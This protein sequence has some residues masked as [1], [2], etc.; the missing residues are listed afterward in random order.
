MAAVVSEATLAA[1][2]TLASDAQRRFAAR[3]LFVVARG[4]GVRRDATERF[5]HEI[6]DRWETA[7]EEWLEALA[8]LP[9][10]RFE[11]ARAESQARPAGGPFASGSDRA[12]DVPDEVAEPPAS[13]RVDGRP[14]GEPLAREGSRGGQRDGAASSLASTAVRGAVV[15]PAGAPSPRREHRV[16]TEE[17]EAAAGGLARA[18]ASGGRDE[19]DAWRRARPDRLLAPRGRAAHADTAGGRHPPA[20]FALHGG[21]GASSSG[22]DERSLDDLRAIIEEGERRARARAEWEATEF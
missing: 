8:R 17:D 9:R 13:G 14:R 7:A 16:E 2:A 1:V 3:R 19:P 20:G 11:P 5:A 15:R 10:E 18:P 21:E 12:G 22:R 6:A 4:A